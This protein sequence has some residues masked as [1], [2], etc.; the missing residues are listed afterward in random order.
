[1][2]KGLMVSALW[3]IEL[4]GDSVKQSGTGTAVLTVA[5]PRARDVSRGD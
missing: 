4:I 1:M 3:N 5:L 2:G